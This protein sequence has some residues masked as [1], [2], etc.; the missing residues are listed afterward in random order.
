MN[1]ISTSINVLP[2]CEVCSS[3]DLPQCV[4]NSYYLILNCNLNMY[5]F[6]G[7]VKLKE[8]EN[9]QLRLFTYETLLGM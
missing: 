8:I 1:K 2:Q 4:Y 5:V 6:L 9:M 3:Q 7:T